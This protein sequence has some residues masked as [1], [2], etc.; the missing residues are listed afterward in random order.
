MLRQGVIRHTFSSAA[1]LV[2]K[3]D[4]SWCMSI[5]YR[6]LNLDMI[7]DQLPIPF[8]KELLDVHIQNTS[9]PSF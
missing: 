4:K 9:A 7:K 5:N 3:Q 6:T 1:L 2:K 8:V